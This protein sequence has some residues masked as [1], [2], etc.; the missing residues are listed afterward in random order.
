MKEI[1]LAKGSF[2]KAKELSGKLAQ[3]KQIY[4]L[5]LM[6]KNT[7]PLDKDMGVDIES[8]LQEFAE[9]SVLN[10][11]RQNIITQINTYTDTKLIDVEPTFVKQ[12]DYTYLTVQIKF[13]YESE[14]TGMRM[15]FENYNKTKEIKL[16][17]N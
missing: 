8:Y 4:N 6:Q 5:V 10:E 17:T 1:I 16:F 9:E 2:G 12:T 15:S 11:L 14:L 3:I 13:K 7:H